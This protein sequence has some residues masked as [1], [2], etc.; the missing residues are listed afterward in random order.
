MTNGRIRQQRLRKLAALVVIGALFFL[1]GTAAGDEPFRTWQDKTGQFEVEAKLLKSADD[2][3]VLLKKDGLSITVPLTALSDADRKFVKEW[4]VKAANPFSGGVPMPGTSVS[5][6]P[7]PAAGDRLLSGGS[8]IDELPVDGQVIRVDPGAAMPPLGADP[9]LAVAKFQRFNCHIEDQDAYARN[10][11]PILVDAATPVFAVSTHRAATGSNPTTYGRLHLVRPGARSSEVVFDIKDTLLLFD[12]HIPSGRSVA[13]IGVN[14]PSE[15]G[16]DLVLLD[17]LA[18]GDPQVLA[19]WHLPEWQKPGF[20]PKV[21]FARLIDGDR[22]VVRVNSTIHIWRLSNGQSLFKLDSVRSKV[23]VSPGGKY[24]A[25]PAG[26]ACHIIDIDEGR[27]VGAIAFP[28]TLTP[29]ARFSPDG[30]RVALV[31]G[32]QFVVWDMSKGVVTAEGKVVNPCGRFFG[33]VGNQYLLTQLGGLID[34]QLGMSLW[35]YGVPSNNQALT[36]R[37]GV[38]MLDSDVRFLC[39]PI[40]HE[41]IE[42][43]EKKLAAGDDELLLIRPG[44][45]VSL[46]VEAIEG[47]DQQAMLAGLRKA[48]EKAGWKVSQNSPIQLAAKIDRGD[49]QKLHF[50]HI[51]QSL[52]SEHETVT[53]RPYTASLVVRRGDDVLWTRSSTNMVPSFFML[54]QGEKLKQAVREYEKAD[55]EYFSRLS[56]PPKILRPE[57]GKSVGRSRIV[58]GAWRDYF[59][60]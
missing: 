24:L 40:P 56:L 27:Q 17:K 57:I 28:S 5:S 8:Q 26:K 23:E 16:G 30:E 45:E 32:N 29:E 2:N 13:V 55:P 41:P 25:V 14:R 9:A 42:G 6:E 20:K 48:V 10:S 39:L 12:H 53:I 18:T 21:E 58:D 43:V 34:P 51:G 49:K 52:W 33:W 15:R 38:A 11:P 35:Y 36:M 3:V 46:E 4:L 19:R 37:G 47:V 1:S 31:A 44:T 59:P 22:A 54:K 60:D 7:V 50:R